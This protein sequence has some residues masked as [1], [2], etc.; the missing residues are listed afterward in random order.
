[1]GQRISYILLAIQLAMLRWNMTTDYKDVEGD[2]RLVSCVLVLTKGK[3]HR[4]SHAGFFLLSELLAPQ[5]GSS[6]GRATTKLLISFFSFTLFQ[7]GYMYP[8]FLH[9]DPSRYKSISPT[10]LR[11]RP[12]CG[13]SKMV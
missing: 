1:M 2:V 9:G 12:F 6:L 4:E 11:S 13:I 10:R 7:V 5:G 8:C 3:G